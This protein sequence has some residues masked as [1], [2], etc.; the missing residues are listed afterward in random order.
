VERTSIDFGTGGEPVETRDHNRRSDGITTGVIEQAL[1]D[2]RDAG[3]VG[4][5]RN[6]KL[7]PLA[8][9]VPRVRFLA[10]RAARRGKGWEWARRKVSVTLGKGE[11]QAALRDCGVDNERALA[12]LE[13]VARRAFNH[14]ERVSVRVMVGTEMRIGD[15]VCLLEFFDSPI[16]EAYCADAG[17]SHTVL[18]ALAMRAVRRAR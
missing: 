8:M 14:P 13:R 5:I 7:R 15:I 11:N 12:V 2:L 17:F 6:G 16:F 1:C 18:R 9:I 3:A 10:A 4:A